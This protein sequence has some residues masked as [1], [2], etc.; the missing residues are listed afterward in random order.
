MAKCKRFHHSWLRYHHGYLY[1]II[2][3]RTPIESHTKQDVIQYIWMLLSAFP[4]VLRKLR[5]EHDRVFDTDFDRT[6]ELLHENPSLIKSLHYTTAV[7]HETL[8]LFPIGMT[9]R[10]AP[11]NL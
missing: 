4:E 10:K 2:L 11:P 6:L 8:R 5:E 9:A 1:C 3:C 7:I